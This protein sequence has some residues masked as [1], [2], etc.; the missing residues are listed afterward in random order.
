MRAPMGGPGLGLSV[1]LGKSLVQGSNCDKQQRR[2]AIA[3]NFIRV[4]R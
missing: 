2:T 3:L 4:G 1:A